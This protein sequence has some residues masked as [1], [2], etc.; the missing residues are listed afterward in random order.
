[1]E[2]GIYSLICTGGDLFLS[3]YM[4]SIQGNQEYEFIV[5]AN[6]KKEAMLLIGM[7]V[8]G[9][10]K[11]GFFN[12]FSNIDLI[13]SPCNRLSKKDAEEKKIDSGTNNVFF[14]GDFKHKNK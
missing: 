5:A 9:L 2:K 13:S 8:F 4:I 14:L 1:M 11:R 7:S 10:K 12:E 6:N 3:Y